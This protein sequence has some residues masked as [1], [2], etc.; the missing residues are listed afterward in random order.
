MRIVVTE[1]E[2]KDNCKCQFCDKVIAELTEDS[3]IPSAEECYQNGN[4]PIPNFGWFC[5]QDCA[6]SYEKKHDISF[7]RSSD[8]RI[9]YYADAF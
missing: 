9:D 2:Q 6:T 4:V 7:A 8:G 5:S 3:M 1:F